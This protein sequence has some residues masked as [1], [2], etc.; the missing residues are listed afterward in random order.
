MEQ[1]FF[2]SNHCSHL[3]YNHSWLAWL[4][5]YKRSWHN[6]WNP[7]LKG[8]GG[9]QCHTR[10][11]VLWEGDNGETI[12]KYFNCDFLTLSINTYKTILW[13]H[14]FFL[15]FLGKVQMI[16][17]L[18]AIDVC[19]PPLILV[20][21]QIYLIR[22]WCQ[23]LYQSLQNELPYPLIPCITLNYPHICR[24]WRL[25]TGSICAIGVAVP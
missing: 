13:F 10:P 11:L 9:G 3:I 14:V 16:L 15:S 7:Y 19:T 24:K 1:F 25:K 5:I 22:F 21:I 23:N 17:Y 20:P 18:Y 2:S 8:G 4:S 6:K 12:L